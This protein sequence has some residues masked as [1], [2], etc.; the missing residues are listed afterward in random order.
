MKTLV[1]LGAIVILSGCSSATKV[2]DQGPQ[3]CYTTQNIQTK[4]GERVESQTQVECS[5]K[6]GHWRKQAGVAKQCIVHQYK[7]DKGRGE[8]HVSQ[9][10]CQHPDGSWHPE[11]N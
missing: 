7:V 1:L 5:D 2:A 3:Y 6:P 9:I 10:R 11:F 8:R 4:N